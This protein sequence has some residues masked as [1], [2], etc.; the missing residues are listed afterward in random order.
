MKIDIDNAKVKTL[1]VEAKERGI[2][3]S[4]KMNRAQLVE[5]LTA[6]QKA[7][8]MI[9]GKKAKAKKTQDTKQAAARKALAKKAATIVDGNPND[10]DDLLGDDDA[11]DV[12]GDE[13]TAPTVKLPNLLKRKFGK[14][15]TKKELREWVTEVW[16][17]VFKLGNIQ[18]KDEH[19]WLG[20]VKHVDTKVQYVSVRLDYL[21]NYARPPKG[22]MKN[23]DV[24]TQRTAIQKAN[25]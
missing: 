5:A 9:N 2:S 19:Y 3:G 13:E 15:A 1:K 17:G 24:A 12:T 7:E 6:I 14:T 10:D 11:E 8:A 4:Y 16:Q 25:S 21:I 20:T 22:S 23:D 18:F